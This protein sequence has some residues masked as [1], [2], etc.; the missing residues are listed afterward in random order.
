MTSVVEL[1]SAIA[2]IFQDYPGGK[3]CS[4]TEILIIY[5]Y[6]E[7]TVKYAQ[8]REYVHLTT[9]LSTSS[10]PSFWGNSSSLIALTKSRSTAEDPSVSIHCTFLCTSLE[11]RVNLKWTEWSS[12]QQT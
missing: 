7:C 12:Q 9:C 5:Y 3:Y 4:V 6:L 1:G 2:Q 8:H 11:W 10:W